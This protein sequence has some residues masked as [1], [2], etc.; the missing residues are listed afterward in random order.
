MWVRAAAAAILAVSLGLWSLVRDLPKTAK[1][2]A[3]F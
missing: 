2:C 1:K 3:S